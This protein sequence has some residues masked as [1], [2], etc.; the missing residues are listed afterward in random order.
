MPADQV[1]NRLGRGFFFLQASESLVHTPGV[2]GRR[3]SIQW[4]TC[5]IPLVTYCQ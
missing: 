2:L 5:I 1:P 3:S 4:D